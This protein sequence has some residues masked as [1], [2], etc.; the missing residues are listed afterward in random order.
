MKLIEPSVELIKQEPD[1][2]GIYKQIERAGRI[3]YK[4]EDKII[5]VV[6][7]DLSKIPDSINVNDLPNY[8]E[9]KEECLKFLKENNI[10][11]SFISSAESFVNMLIKNGHGAMLEHGTVYLKIPIEEYEKNYKNKYFPQE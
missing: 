4:S 3:C 7:I 1:I 8:K 9:N 11:Y 2:E 5:D 10:P 6:K